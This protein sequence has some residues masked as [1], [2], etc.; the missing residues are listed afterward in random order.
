[1]PLKSAMV[2]ELDEIRGVARTLGVVNTVA[3]ERGASGSGASGG[4]GD[5][6]RLVGY[7]TDVAG[8]VNALRHA[9]RSLRRTR[10]C[11]AAAGRQLPRSLP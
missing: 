4:N 3:F 8:I 7:N 1:M 10:L 5:V 11:W 2:A 6:T 9:A